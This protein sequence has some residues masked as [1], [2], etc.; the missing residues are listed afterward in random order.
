L[1]EIV[2]RENDLLESINLSATLALEYLDCS[3]NSLTELQIIYNPL[4]ENL[5]C[6]HNLIKDLDLSQNINL[7]FL[8]CNDNELESLDLRNGS[9]ALMTGGMTYFNEDYVYMDGMDSSNNPSLLCIQVDDEETANQGIAPYDSWVKDGTA[10]YSQ[11]CEAN[12]G[13]EQQELSQMIQVYPNPV[14]DAITIENDHWDI[15]RVILY[16]IQGRKI[17]QFDSHF[18]TIALNDI[19]SG[20]YF[21]IIYTEKGVAAKRIVKK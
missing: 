7:A 21:L 18:E 14:Q 9:N 15:H 6:H 12:L 5:Y 1:K 16:S 20:L 11:N 13:L 17:K 3:N 2:C 8:K 19:S 10:S 4:L